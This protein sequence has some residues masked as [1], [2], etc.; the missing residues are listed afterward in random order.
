MATYDDFVPAFRAL[1]V[2]SGGSFPAFYAE[3]ERLAGLEPD[4]RRR[5]LDSLATGGP[6]PPE[7]G[8]DS[9]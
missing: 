4:E 1:L 3:V 5:A 2:S 6:E 7:P 9:R 8:P